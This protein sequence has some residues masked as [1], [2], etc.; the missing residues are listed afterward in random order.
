MRSGVEIV[1]SLVMFEEEEEGIARISTTK[2]QPG[3]LPLPRCWQG[4]FGPTP[5]SLFALRTALDP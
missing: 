3:R 1:R 2:T 5:C 4:V